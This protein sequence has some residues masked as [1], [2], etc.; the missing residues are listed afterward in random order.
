MHDHEVAKNDLIDFVREKYANDH[1]E[2]Q[3]IAEF[4]M[5]YTT[6]VA[7]KWYTR[8]SFV[9]RQLNQALR[10]KDLKALYMF[11]LLIIDIYL[12]LNKLQDNKNISLK[13]H[14]LYRGQSISLKEVEQFQQS[15]G[16]YISMN[17]FLSTSANKQISLIFS[18][19]RDGFEPVLFD[20]QADTKLIRAKNP[21]QTYPW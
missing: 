9:Y 7:I 3:K 18:E 15:I 20:I 12:Q 21:L 1:I 4:S 2:L 5:N 6:D 19:A 8:D 16:K 11:P 10:M 14:H 17:S 13:I